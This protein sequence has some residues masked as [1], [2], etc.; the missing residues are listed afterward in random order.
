MSDNA[1][2]LPVRALDPVQACISAINA[3]LVRNP[4]HAEL[5]L[6]SKDVAAYA[7]RAFYENGYSVVVNEQAYFDAKKYVI[8]VSLTS[9]FEV[10]PKLDN[11]L[12]DV[13]Q[14]GE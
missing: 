1:N 8:S 4:N 3:Q 9:E 13:I 11:D 12:Y 5:T 7:A 6:N 14:E 10:N 2:E